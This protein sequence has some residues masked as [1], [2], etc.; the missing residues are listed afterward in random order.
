MREVQKIDRYIDKRVLGYMNRYINTLLQERIIIHFCKLVQYIH[1]LIL[2]IMQVLLII[3]FF[4][5]TN[6]MAHSSLTKGISSKAVSFLPEYLGL[7]LHM[8][9]IMNAVATV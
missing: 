6:F 8:Y 2:N 1:V 7:C 3:N 5:S 4:I 9:N